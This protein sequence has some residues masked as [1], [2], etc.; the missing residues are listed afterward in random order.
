MGVSDDGQTCAAD[1]INDAKS[2]AS[3]FPRM[4]AVKRAL[5]QRS[6]PS[7]RLAT[8]SKGQDNTGGI[9]ADFDR[10]NVRYLIFL[11]CNSE[12]A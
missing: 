2:P 1:L 3:R 5:V 4:D 11:R 9:L 10:C 7:N 12:N 6:H 8:L